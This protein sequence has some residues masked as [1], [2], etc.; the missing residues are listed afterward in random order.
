L[1]E[2]KVNGKGAK[3]FGNFEEKREEGG[4]RDEVPTS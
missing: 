2:T 1:S 4:R 3:C